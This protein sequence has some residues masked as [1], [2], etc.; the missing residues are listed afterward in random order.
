MQSLVQEAISQESGERCYFRYKALQ[1]EHPE[2]S[3]TGTHA[4]QCQLFASQLSYAT[5]LDS[6]R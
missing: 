3:F 6:W 5:A 4:S 2:V 1:G